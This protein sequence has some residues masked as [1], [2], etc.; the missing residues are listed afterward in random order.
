[1]RVTISAVRSCPSDRAKA[2]RDEISAIETAYNNYS[3]ERIRDLSGVFV[4]K[5]QRDKHV[6][7]G[8]AANADRYS[9]ASAFADNG[10]GQARQMA[11]ERR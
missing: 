1:M 2:I 6:I 8:N 9:N 10:G 11:E 5:M 7:E 3:D 4:E